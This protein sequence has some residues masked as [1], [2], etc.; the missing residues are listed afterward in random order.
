MIDFDSFMIL[1]L[2]LCQSSKQQ[3]SDFLFNL[4]TAYYYKHLFNQEHNQIAVS[5]YLHRDSPH[6]DQLVSKML[7]I[8]LFLFCHHAKCLN[9]DLKFKY[10][11]SFEE[12]VSEY[13]VF[14]L[15]E[16]FKKEYLG[17]ITQEFRQKVFGNLKVVNKEM[18]AESAMA[19]VFADER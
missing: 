1:G 19:H 17:N 10:S 7:D 5:D 11:L 12:Y 9:D 4:F 2:F 14:K 16:E 6:I 13:Q 8:S 15:S 3:R 18:F